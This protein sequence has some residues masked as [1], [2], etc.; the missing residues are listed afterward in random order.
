MHHVVEYGRHGM[1][2]SY[3]RVLQL[4]RH[5]SI[6]EISYGSPESSFLYILWCHSN[7]IVSAESILEGKHGVSCCRIY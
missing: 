5:H 2:V 7:L 6:V 4:E 1:L 3:A